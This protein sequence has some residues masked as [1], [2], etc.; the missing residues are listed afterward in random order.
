M[1]QIPGI[2]F[3]VVFLPQHR[4]VWH[5][6]FWIAL[7]LHFS[8]EQWKKCL[9]Y[10]NMWKKI[11]NETYRL[12][13]CIYLME[14]IQKNPSGL[15]IITIWTWSLLSCMCIV[16]CLDPEQFSLSVSW[17]LQSLA[18]CECSVNLYFWRWKV[19][20]NIQIFDLSTSSI[21]MIPWIF[22]VFIYGKVLK[23]DLTLP[24]TLKIDH[25][26]VPELQ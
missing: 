18:M 17:Y 20:L 11:N 16:N 10:M 7:Y 24:R 2:L 21:Y 4:F 3:V 8:I 26:L 23:N 5:S 13:E 19:F 1:A 6:K 15:W 25:K 12:P 22:S 14:G 9:S